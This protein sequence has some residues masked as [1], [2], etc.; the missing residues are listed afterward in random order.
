M[1]KLIKLQVLLFLLILTARCASAEV[2]TSSEY[3]FSVDIPKDYIVF[4][5]DMDE[6]NPF[7]AVMGMTKADMQELLNENGQY[8]CGFRLKDRSQINISCEKIERYDKE[9]ISKTQAEYMQTYL[10]EEYKKNGKNVIKSEL[11]THPKVRMVMVEFSRED[12]NGHE[13][14]Y[15]CIYDDVLF[16]VSVKAAERGITKEHGRIIKRVVDSLDFPSLA[17]LSDSYEKTDSF[18]YTDEG[19]MGFRVP[20]NWK[21]TGEKSEKYTKSISFTSTRDTGVSMVYASTDTWDGLPFYVKLV[22]VGEGAEEEKLKAEDVAE[23]IGVADL[24]IEEVEYNGLIYKRAVYME[25]AKNMGMEIPIPVTVLVRVDKGIIHIFQF[26]GSMDNEHY[27]EFEEVI[28]SVHYPGSIELLPERAF[29]IKLSGML[30]YVI[31]AL[32]A[33]VIVIFIVLKKKS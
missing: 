29:Y 3:G 23:L 5:E 24:Q 30:P 26:L 13:I 22:S 1:N 8:L 9:P 27:P 4:S 2:F 16:A 33:V 20:E 31:L 11:Y 25:I 19:G 32:V 28:R 7:L 14:K 12:G 18:S 15:H 21:V 6:D 17:E 10:E